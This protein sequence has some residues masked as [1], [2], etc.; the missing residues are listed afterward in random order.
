M[1]TCHHL[2]IVLFVFC[3]SIQESRATDVRSADKL[4]EMKVSLLVSDNSSKAYIDFK[5]IYKGMD[6]IIVSR[7]NLIGSRVFENVNLQAVSFLDYRKSRFVKCPKPIQNILIDDA[8]VGVEKI[9]HNAVLEQRIDLNEVYG[10]MSKILG[11]CDL[12]IYW[13]YKIDV[14]SGPQIERLAGALVIP[15]DIN[16]DKRSKNGD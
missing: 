6:P 8:G 14:Q 2:L 12:V 10:N 13:S 3:I 16:L 11:R 5:M 4:V 1:K 15:S 9:S 7:D